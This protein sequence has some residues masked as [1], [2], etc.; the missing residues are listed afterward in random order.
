M[1]LKDSQAKEAWKK[2]LLR[3]K[4]INISS[5]SKTMNIMMNLIKFT[6]L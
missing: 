1:I 6:W 4:M 3:V 5:K 2:N